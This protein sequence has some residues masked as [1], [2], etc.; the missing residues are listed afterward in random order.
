M[1]NEIERLLRE[2]GIA[3]GSLPQSREKSLVLT[4]LDEAAQWHERLVLNSLDWQAAAENLRRRLET[5]QKLH[6]P[7]ATNYA[8]VI[9]LLIK[10]LLLRYTSGER[11]VKLHH[12]MMDVK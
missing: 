11:T 1:E 5:Y 9:D 4:K 8:A 7:P 2:L 3:V 12:A 6:N 10:P